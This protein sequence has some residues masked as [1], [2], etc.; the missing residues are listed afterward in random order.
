MFRKLVTLGGAAVALTAL[1]GPT[2]AIGLPVPAANVIFVSGSTALDNA[3][4]HFMILSGVSPCTA[5]TIDTYE[6]NNKSNPYKSSNL[7][8]IIACTSNQAIGSIASGQPVAFVKESS[9]GSLEGTTPVSLHTTLKFLDPTAAGGPVGCAA[10]VAGTVYS[11]AHDLAFTDHT[12]CTGPVNSFGPNVGLADENPTVFT[13]GQNKA[14]NV[15]ISNLTTNLMFQNPFGIGVSLNLYRALQVQQGLSGTVACPVN[16]DTLACMPDMSSMAVR[17]TMSQFLG[18]GS[19]ASLHGLPAPPSANNQVF[20]C[21]RGD[22]SGTQ[23]AADIYLF[24]GRCQVT[25]NENPNNPAAMTFAQAT[26]TA[27]NCANLPAGE[28][29]EDFGCTW[30]AVNVNDTVFPG[31]GTG[32]V[33]KC[34]AAHDTNGTY[35]IGVIATNNAFGHV[36]GAAGA[37]D[38]RMTALDGAHPTTQ[39]QANGTYHFAMDNVVNVAKNGTSAAKAYQTL[40]ATK[41]GTN[42][43]VLGDIISTQVG[44]AN[45]GV[46]GLF[47]ILT[48]GS[49]PAL[50]ATLAGVQANPTSAGTQLSDGAT[51]NDCVKVTPNGNVVMTQDPNN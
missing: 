38:Y 11:V 13:L 6:D 34:L 23:A 36:N 41:L 46:G 25:D 50:P 32:D 9:G 51:Q 30:A 26:T 19:W 43:A 20:V 5:G 45:Y 21:R 12:A 8:T 42:T 37:G 3:W 31:T 48:T 14:T 1:T 22:T 29:P 28:T 24:N 49:Q 27:A 7:Y 39:S 33:A 16:S 44:D 35:A 47:D 40:L 2:W 15:V 18:S 4:K 17:S 10:A